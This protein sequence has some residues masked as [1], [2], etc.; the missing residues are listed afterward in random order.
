MSGP[1][2][3]QAVD[4]SQRYNEQLRAVVA[5]AGALTA[6]LPMPELLDRA[7]HWAVVL[8]GHDQ[9]SIMLIERGGRDLLIRAVV[10][11]DPE[12]VGRVVRI[13][14]SNVAGWVLQ[15][16]QP[17]YL[18]GRGASFPGQARSYTKDLPSS[19]VLPLL[20]IQGAPLGVI[21]LNAT[22][23]TVSLTPEDIEVLQAMANIVA[24]AIDGANMY[25][26][27][28]LKD[29]QLQAAA[30]QLVKAQEE[31][32]K[33]VAYDIHDGLAQMIA[34]TYQRLQGFRAHRSLRTAE[35][36]H[37]LDQVQRQLKLTLEEVRRIIGDLRPS[38]LDDFGLETALRQYL[39]ERQAE[40]GW[41]LQVDFDLHGVE[42]P[43]HLET[44]VFRIVQEAAT[45]VVKHAASPRLA[46]SV[47]AGRRWLDV[48]V[49]DWGKGFRAPGT[50]GVFDGSR[51]GL[52]S[53]A[54]RAAVL[55][56]VFKLSSRPGRGTRVHVRL[57]LNPYART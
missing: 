35:A 48:R 26:A 57:P 16:R 19:V 3:S 38:V 28:Q 11:Q 47:S 45:N 2:K 15:N 34:G 33:R 30:T 41:D 53:M 22:R 13:S 21:S 7:L 36:Q 50:N 6:T 55:G 54:D 5:M 39:S 42:L 31:E 12:R 52:A 37:E 56:G 23:G 8:S 9:G 20:N 27:L 44:T 29:L 51:V 32:R 1:T 40:A 25:G 14:S 4:P 18:E 17:L 49:Q 46:V 24:V 10:G 43:A